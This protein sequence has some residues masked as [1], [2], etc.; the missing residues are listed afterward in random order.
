ME[1]SELVREPKSMSARGSVSVTNHGYYSDRDEGDTQQYE[2]DP[3]LQG[4]EERKL[5]VRFA[6]FDLL[7][8]HGSI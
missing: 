5:L 7:I 1:S 4:C 2:V 6:L 3:R 8:D